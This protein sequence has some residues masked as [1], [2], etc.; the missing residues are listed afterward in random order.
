[1]EKKSRHIEFIY[2]CMTACV[3]IR[4]YV[5]WVGADVCCVYA[6]MCEYGL[7]LWCVWM[8]AC[9]CKWLCARACVRVY[10]VVCAR[11]HVC[12]CKWLCVRVHVCVCIWLSVCAG[13]CACARASVYIPTLA[14]AISVSLYKPIAS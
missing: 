8:R 1:M 2:V 9:A 12:V 14:T 13:M 7:V 5:K 6:C 4:A 3:H 10:V 11:V